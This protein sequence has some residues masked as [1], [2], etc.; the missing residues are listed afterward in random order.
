MIKQHAQ[1][2]EVAKTTVNRP[3][4]DGPVNASWRVHPV[5]RALIYDF[6]GNAFSDSALDM[7]R[8]CAV[9]EAEDEQ[10]HSLFLRPGGRLAAHLSLWPKKIRSAAGPVAIG[11]IGAV[12]VDPDY[13]GCGLLHRLF[14]EAVDH[15]RGLGLR[16][17]V[18]GGSPDI[19]RKVGFSS[20]LGTVEYILPTD[21]LRACRDITEMPLV[22]A[23][24][25]LSNWQELYGI[26]SDGGLRIRRQQ[27]WA[28]L[29]HFFTAPPAHFRCLHSRDGS[30]MLIA[31]ERAH[32]LFIRELLTADSR[33]L[34]PLLA[35]LA[36]LNP[37]LE[38][39]QLYLGAESP[40]D[41]CLK[42]WVKGRAG[43]TRTPAAGTQWRSLDPTL[44]I[45]S[46]WHLS[47]LDRR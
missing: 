34:L 13:R 24:P 7:Y 44:E 8:T 22:P 45:D 18:L 11:D 38:K 39:I 30:T 25:G 14:S 12:V 3:V 2:A 26:G 21:L 35:T 1:T 28:R 41:R 5:D 42:D 27:Y 40:L 19:Y 43:T 36:A 37:A 9:W 47:T 16:A 10:P 29:N 20:N 32:T 15:A 6:I 23:I 17:L 4:I 31:V 33:S 46:H